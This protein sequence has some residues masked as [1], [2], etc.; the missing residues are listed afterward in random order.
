MK[1][2]D[3]FVSCLV[4][5]EVKL[6]FSSFYAV[7]NLMMATA[8]S[9]LIPS[10]CIWF[11]KFHVFLYGLQ[12]LVIFLGKS[13]SAQQIRWLVS[14]DSGLHLHIWFSSSKHV[15]NIVSQCALC[16]KCKDVQEIF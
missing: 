9:L 14:R 2:R 16:L 4:L 11:A 10:F 12:S 1:E 8:V 3:G 7:S 5:V 6:V 13:K 15:V